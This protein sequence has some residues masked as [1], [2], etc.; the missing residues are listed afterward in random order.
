MER[1]ADRGAFLGAQSLKRKG[2]KSGKNAAFDA[3]VSR[4]CS[5]RGNSKSSEQNVVGTRTRN[6]PPT[7]GAPGMRRNGV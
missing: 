3:A 7:W 6:S 1:E 2:G 5:D 4:K